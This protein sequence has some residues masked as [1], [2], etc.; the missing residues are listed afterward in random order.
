MRDTKPVLLIGDEKSRG[1]RLLICQ[2][3]IGCDTYPER[4]PVKVEGSVTDPLFTA[5]SAEG[6]SRRDDLVIGCALTY[7]PEIV[8]PFV[9]SLRS[10]GAFTGH[11]ALLVGDADQELKAYLESQNFEAVSFE[12]TRY[13]VPNLHM[14]RYFGYFAYLT[15]QMRNGT[16]YRYILLSDVRDVTFQKPLFSFPAPELEFH[17]ENETSRLGNDAWNADRIR[18]AFGEETLQR[19]ARKRISCSGTV[20]GQPEGIFDYLEKMQSTILELPA[21]VKSGVGG[22]QAVHNFLLHEGSLPQVSILE[23][24]ARVATLHLVEGATLRID[25]KARVVNPDGTVSEIA[26]QWDR[27]AHLRKAILAKAWAREG[28]FNRAALAIRSRLRNMTSHKRFPFHLAKSRA[29]EI[30]LARPR[31]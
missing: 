31:F 21:A 16:R 11:A 18:E 5:A 27:H 24:F 6:L 25:G 30:S 20:S 14:A 1:T 10:A 15:A 26:H 19:L 8:R 9:E 2:S 17:Y 22:D 12:P 29:V 28:Y 3:Q 23:N 13:G 7:T 4:V